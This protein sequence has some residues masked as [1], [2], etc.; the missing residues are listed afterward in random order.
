[1]RI[2]SYDQVRLIVDF[3]VGKELSSRSCLMDA[4]DTIKGSF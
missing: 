3:Y 2:I 1:M 4:G